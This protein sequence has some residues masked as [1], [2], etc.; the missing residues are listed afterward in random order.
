MPYPSPG[1]LPDPG[2]QPRSPTL[3]A[4]SI[5][6]ATREAPQMGR[7]VKKE[8]KGAAVLWGILGMLKEPSL[9]EN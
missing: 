1:D 2:L 7:I 8:R 5:I 6:C 3:Q 9:L 4:D